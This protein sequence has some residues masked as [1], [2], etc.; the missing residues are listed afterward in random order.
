MT[1]I[2]Q[3]MLVAA[4]LGLAGC[5][6]TTTN[7]VTAV[8]GGAAALGGLVIGTATAVGSAGIAATGAAVGAAGGA[9]A[10]LAGS[11]AV[12]TVAVTTPDAAA[13]ASI[14]PEVAAAAPAAQ[15]TAVAAEAGGGAILAVELPAAA[16]L[17]TGAAFAQQAFGAAGAEA[18]PT[19]ETLLASAR[20][21]L[22]RCA[23]QVFMGVVVAAGE[24]DAARFAVWLNQQAGTSPYADTMSSFRLVAEHIETHLRRTA[25]QARVALQPLL[26]V[27]PDQA[28]LAFTSARDVHARCPSGA[29]QRLTSLVVA[30]QP[31][32]T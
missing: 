30:D 22:D 15:A 24:A 16:A 20:G 18:V 5:G 9:A 27:D 21:E 6:N 1:R 4:G 23:L 8:A 29:A 7:T 25:E 31:R 19:A 10:G 12:T 3:A 28:R 14:A 26:D 13:A 17:T 2:G 11:G 32:A